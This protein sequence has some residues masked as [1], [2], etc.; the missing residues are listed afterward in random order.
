MSNNNKDNWETYQPSLPP[1]LG[2]GVNNFGVAVKV[3]SPID[4]AFDSLEPITCST[5]MENSDEEV[6]TIT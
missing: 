2:I 1:T 5:S 6:N 4:I 3:H